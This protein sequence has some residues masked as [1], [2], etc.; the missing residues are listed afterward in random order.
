MRRDF[1]TSALFVKESVWDA[2]STPTIDKHIRLSNLKALYMILKGEDPLANQVAENLGGVAPKYKVSLTDSHKK[3]LEDSLKSH[4]EM[5]RSVVLPS[6]KDYLCMLAD[7]DFPV[8]LVIKE[9]LAASF[10]FVEENLLHDFP[11]DR[12]LTLEYAF[13]LYH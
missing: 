4:E 5:Y 13:S 3:L 8:E 7:Y 6:L 9:Q 11:D 10:F 2:L 1:V 12:P